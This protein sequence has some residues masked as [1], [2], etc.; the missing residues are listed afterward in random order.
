MY[1]RTIFRPK[2]ILLT[3]GAG[4]IG[5][6]L[7]ELLLKE[8]CIVYCIDNLDPYYPEQ[9]KRR[10]LT[11]SLKHERFHFIQEDFT[12]MRGSWW[13]KA[14][15]RVQFDAIIHLG[16][17][18]GVRPSIHQSLDYYNTNLT[19]TQQLL[20]CAREWSVPKF[21]FA[22][23]SSVYGNCR[24]MPWR[25]EDRSGDPISPYASSKLAAEQLGRVYAHL[26]GLQFIALRLFTV[27]GPRQRPDLAI[28]KFYKCIEAG[29]PLTIFGDGESSRD[30]TFIEDILSGIV[31]ALDYAGEKTVFNLGGSDPVRLLDLVHILEDTMGKKAKLIQAPQQDGDVERTCADIRRAAEHL[32]YAPKTSIESGIESFVRWKKNTKPQLEYQD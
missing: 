9:I 32:Q 27:Y 5:S 22:S 30:Y 28:H 1:M 14:L 26:F 23:S 4:F 3:G 16:G 2:S 17:K 15:S 7:S 20:E 19:G 12:H 31:A 29:E 25:E 11:Y 21:I 6:H 13:A 24:N 18:A 10:N 8:G